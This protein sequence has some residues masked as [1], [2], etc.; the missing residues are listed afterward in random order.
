[1]VV[2]WRSKLKQEFN[3]IN[4]WYWLDAAGFWLFCRVLSFLVGERCVNKLVSLS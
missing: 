2:Q 1:M 4:N 3:V